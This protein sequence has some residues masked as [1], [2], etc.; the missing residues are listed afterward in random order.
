M[1]VLFYPT[2]IFHQGKRGFHKMT[3]LEWV[4]VFHDLSWSWSSERFDIGII[5]SKNSYWTVLQYLR[6]TSHIFSIMTMLFRF[7]LQLEIS[8]SIIMYCNCE[9]IK[10]SLSW[11]HEI[12]SEGTTTSKFWNRAN[13][14]L[15]NFHVESGSG[16]YCSTLFYFF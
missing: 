11:Q 2:T 7:V 15:I 3:E 6:A 14:G 9:S 16:L 8:I 4:I 10:S 1:I 5:N 12:T 13:N